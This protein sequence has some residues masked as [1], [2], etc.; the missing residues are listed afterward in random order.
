M[1]G[2]NLKPQDQESHAS[3]LSQQVLQKLDMQEMAFFF[4]SVV[5]TSKNNPYSQVHMITIVCSVA[6]SPLS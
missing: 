6:T 2:S 5:K 3:R 4:S 1:Q